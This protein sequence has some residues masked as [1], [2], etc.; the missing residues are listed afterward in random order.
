MPEQAPNAINPNS[1]PT[2]V[3]PSG[4]V[5]P[6]SS[7]SSPAFRAADAYNSDP[8]FNWPP[9]RRLGWG[10]AGVIVWIAI[11]S[12]GV[13]IPS[14]KSR[15][16]LGWRPKGDSPTELVKLQADVEQLQKQAAAPKTPEGDVRL[17]LRRR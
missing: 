7:S 11:F 8:P 5:P 12:A 15:A 16:E 2:S 4:P 1:V 9:D 3:P 10:L 14:E 13:L 17:P 6:A